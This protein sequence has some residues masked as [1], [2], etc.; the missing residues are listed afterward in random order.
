MPGCGRDRQPHT[1]TGFVDDDDTRLLLLNPVNH[2]LAD[3][4]RDGCA[5]MALKLG[6][7]IG[8][9]VLERSDEQ[10]AGRLWHSKFVGLNSQQ[11]FTRFCGQFQRTI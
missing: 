2:A 5:A 7:G 6:V 11:T 3:D 8:S 9:R 1:K 10:K 4:L